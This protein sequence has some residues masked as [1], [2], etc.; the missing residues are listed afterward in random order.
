MTSDPFTPKP[1]SPL[2]PRW[3][4]AWQRFQVDGY[5]SMWFKLFLQKI[6]SGSWSTYPTTCQ[7][8]IGFTCWFKICEKSWAFPV[9]K[10]VTPWLHVDEFCRSFFQ[11]TW[12]WWTPARAFLQQDPNSHWTVSHRCCLWGGPSCC[13]WERERGEG[14]SCHVTHPECGCETIILHH[15]PWQFWCATHV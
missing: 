5:D 12:M 3:M 15:L 4:G 1:I 11:V 13:G 10:P 9:R 2:A 6:P 7:W 8:K 14:W